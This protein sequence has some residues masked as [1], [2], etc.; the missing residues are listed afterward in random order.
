M[1]G[2]IIFALVAALA[3]G[4]APA[5][6]AFLE[7][8]GLLGGQ[9]DGIALG[10][11][12]NLWIG[13]MSND[14][15]VRMDQTGKVLQRYAVGGDA[16]DITTGPGG[17]VWAAVDIDPAGG[18][19]VWFDALSASPT[20][21][22]KSTNGVST[23]GPVAVESGGDGKMYMTLPQA[24]GCPDPSRLGFFNADGTGGPTVVNDAGGAQALDIAV[25]G[26][27][28]FVPDFAG[29]V[30]RRRA[31]NAALTVETTITIPGGGD[32]AA[33]SG[34][35]AGNVWTTLRNGNGVAR[36]MA[37]QNGG[38]ATVLTPSGGSLTTPFGIV[39]GGDGG[40]Y[41]AGFNSTNVARIDRATN[42]FT[43]FAGPA[44]AYPWRIAAGTDDDFWVTD[45]GNARVL[46]LLRGA[47]RIGTLNLGA[48]SPTSA[49][50]DIQIDPRGAPTQLV[51]DYGPTAAYGTTTSPISIPAGA[52]FTQQRVTLSG[53][54]PMT[55]YHARARATNADGESSTGDMVFNTPPSPGLPPGRTPPGVLPPPNVVPPGVL[56]ARI[57]A[58]GRASRRFTR[59]TRL[60][61]RQ[62][63]GG[64]TIVVTCTGRGCPFRTRTTR[65][66]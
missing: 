31:L 3:L 50:L 65:S 45:R 66:V 40:M 19:L 47:P 34:D 64:E 51:V 44:D 8:G 41:A 59:I 1:P 49:V 61:V 17:R 56:P 42:A 15:I 30:V 46:R 52:G 25:A 11:D 24:E 37:S 62:L 16:S 36:F 29:D 32:P 13:T 38:V 12:G 57:D 26:G 27:K 53:L 48:D 23:C 2:R 35:G 5:Q 4:A 6:A 58:R 43:F 14:S 33:I 39:P 9:T 22:D 20:A 21:H 54:S 63:T 55:D 10:P 60:R 18:K 7:Y 28:L